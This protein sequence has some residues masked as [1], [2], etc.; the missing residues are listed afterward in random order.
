MPQMQAGGL[1]MIDELVKGVGAGEASL[2]GAMATI[3]GIIAAGS[4]KLPETIGASVGDVMDVLKDLDKSLTVDLAQALINGTDPSGIEANLA[5]VADMLGDLQVQADA[6]A[7]SI[8]G[9]NAVT[10]QVIKPPSGGSSSG[11]SG[12]SRSGGSGGSGTRIGSQ[13]VL[14]M[15]DATPLLTWYAYESTQSEALWP[16]TG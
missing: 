9:V 1:S 3:Q 13:T 2:G 12:D 11:G 14:M 8:K 16:V 5:V 6:T 7:K 15:P 4:D 10:G